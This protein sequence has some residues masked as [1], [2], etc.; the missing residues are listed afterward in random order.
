MNDDNALVGGLV[1]FTYGILKNKP[2]ARQAAIQF[3]SAIDRKSTERAIGY[4]RLGE[5]GISLTESRECIK[6]KI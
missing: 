2:D 5:I 3:Y 6:G 4:A 1:A